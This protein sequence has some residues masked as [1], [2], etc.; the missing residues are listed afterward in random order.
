MA[1]APRTTIFVVRHGDR[2]DYEVGR[3]E[4][5]AR[6]KASAALAASDP[7]LSSLGHQQ[8]R[9]LA[10]YLAKKGITRILV[11]PYLR[12][13]QT[14]Q[15]LAHATG[16]PLLVDF[17][18][19]E[20][21]Q[22]PAALPATDARLPYF[23]EIDESYEPMMRT[24]MTDDA[25]G[26]EPGVEPRLEHM[27]RMLYLARTLLVHPSF[28]GQTVAIV[29][30]AASMAL[31]SALTGAPSLDAA[32]KLAA[33]GAYKIVLGSDGVATLVER[34]DDSSAYLTC[35]ASTTAAWG[36]ADSAEPLDSSETMWREA[37][38]L[39]P[40]DPSAL[41][42]CGPRSRPLQAASKDDA[43]EPE[44]LLAAAPATSPRSS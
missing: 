22:R 15:P 33:C 40:T 7:P 43:Y 4:W 3:E 5:T 9:E 24:V 2:Y 16:V 27:R 31:V 17:A 6:C 37:M 11:S 44:S 35:Q 26:A 19:A 42:P 32:G 10:A 25:D 1:A 28:A 12:A 38:R 23:P 34:G 30:H 18:V 14:A 21:H 20:S 36:F 13:L 8:A 41:P 39:G 29:T